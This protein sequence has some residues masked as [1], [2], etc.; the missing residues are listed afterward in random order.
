MHHTVVMYSVAL[1]LSF[2][3]L[4]CFT[5]PQAVGESPDFML[6]RSDGTTRLMADFRIFLLAVRVVCIVAGGQ[7]NEPVG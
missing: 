7:F 6:P 4:L 1:A 5:E 2:T 3:R